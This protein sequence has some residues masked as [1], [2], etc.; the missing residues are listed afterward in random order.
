[1][2]E[3]PDILGAKVGEFVLFPIAPEVF[4]RIEFGG[5]GGEISHGEMVAVDFQV[6]QDPPAATDLGAVPDN[7]EFTWEEA[8]ELTQEGD[9]LGGADRAPVQSEAKRSDAQAG[10]GRQLLPVVAVGED[11]RFPDRGPSAYPMGLFAQAALVDERRSFVPPSGLFFNLGPLLVFPGGDG[12]FVA[13][14][15]P[16]NERFGT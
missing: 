12:L 15:G 10:D 5:I 4:N 13:F 9:D 14:F 2:T 1:V 11:G 7:E 8:L 3:V 6:A 16:G